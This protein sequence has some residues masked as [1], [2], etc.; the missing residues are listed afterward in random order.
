[1]LK[2]V[3]LKLKQTTAKKERFFL[4]YDKHLISKFMTLITRESFFVKELFNYTDIIQAIQLI[5][6]IAY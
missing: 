5:V 3:L 2:K 6:K 1:M 4:I